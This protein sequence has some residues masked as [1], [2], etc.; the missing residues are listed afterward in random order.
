MV[1]TGIRAALRVTAVPVVL[2]LA[3][4]AAS[5]GSASAGPQRARLSSDLTDYLDR[6]LASRVPV[7]VHGAE[8]RIDQAAARHGLTVQKR[9]AGGGILL[10][11]AR[12]LDALAADPAVGHVSGD[13]MVESTASIAERA[14]GAD[15]AWRFA[16]RESQLTGRGVGVAVIDSGDRRTTGRSGTGWS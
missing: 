13:V 12:Q 11:D 2:V 3:C 15:I 5:A 7:I 4:L 14:I 9:I 16:N 8:S 1:V 10:V 6:G